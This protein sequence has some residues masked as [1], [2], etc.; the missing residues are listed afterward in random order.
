MLA[1]ICAYVDH[2]DADDAFAD[3]VD[4]ADDDETARPDDTSDPFAV[5]ATKR[6]GK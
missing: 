3:H 5:T 1:V 4:R 6:A 2:Q